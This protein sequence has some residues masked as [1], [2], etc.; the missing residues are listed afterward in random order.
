MDVS[1]IKDFLDNLG[2]WTLTVMAIIKVLTSIFVALQNGTF[3]LKN[4]G[5]M[6]KDDFLKL[7]VVTMM[8]VFAPNQNFAGITVTDGIV[9]PYIAYLGIRIA[10]NLGAMF[11]MFGNA[12]PQQVR[13]TVDP[14][15]SLEEVER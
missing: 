8:V 11:P 12:L 9:A 15:K 1:S 10:A 4:F 3:Q 5:D 7:T 6:F 14:V 13:A 2:L